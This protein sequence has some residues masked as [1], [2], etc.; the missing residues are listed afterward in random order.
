[1]TMKKLLLIFLL[2]SASA[3]A[4]WSV[5]QKYSEFGKGNYYLF[6]STE[7]DARRIILETLQD[8]QLSYDLV[9]KKGAN[10]LLTTA[11]VDPLNSEYVYVIH[12]MKGQ[13]YN[14]IGYH[15]FCYYMENR[16]R[17]FYDITEGE[18][19]ISLIYDPGVLN[20]SPNK[21]KNNK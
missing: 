18:N 7:K 12:S 2:A 6:A 10:L 8:N 5:M 4:Q 13:Y 16:Y 11:V 9:F 3:N 21:D 19:R 17:Y 1:M 20:V 14:K 15:V